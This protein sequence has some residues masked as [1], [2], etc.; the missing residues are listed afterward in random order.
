M[1]LDII[2]HVL[3]SVFKRNLLLENQISHGIRSLP[4]EKKVLSGAKFAGFE[5]LLHQWTSAALE[6]KEK[7]INWFSLR[8]SVQNKI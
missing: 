1:D 4:T 2:T 8:K 6:V 7:N 5:M 3:L